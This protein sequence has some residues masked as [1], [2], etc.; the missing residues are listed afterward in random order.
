MGRHVPGH[1]NIIIQ[2]M[3]GAGSLKATNYLASV[4]AADGS[5]FGMPN[6]VN[7]TEPLIDPE[8]T[9]FDPR[10]FQWLGSLNTETA[11][12]GFWAKDISKADDLKKRQIVV[13]STGPASGS[14]IDAKALAALLKLDIKI[15]SGY[16]GLTEVRLAAERGEVDG[17]CGLLVSSIKTDV[18]DQ[19]KSG[20]I[21]VPLQMGLTRHPDLGDVPNAYDLVTSEEDRALFRLIFGPWS[22]G[23]P[24]MAPPNTPP[25]RVAALRNAVQATLKDP[26]FQADAKRLN[27]EVQPVG[28]EAI[29][30]TVDELFRT[31]EPVLQRARTMLGVS[32]R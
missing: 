32:A 21:K 10:K 28:H 5:V 12:C 1:P 24:L 29:A 15:V 19:Y 14:T 11:T 23:R 2:H 20:K 7:T 8:R 26:A 27:L 30:R 6:P 18:W 13:G 9:K 16:P 22:Y 4:A 17:H 3:P 25:D 31:P